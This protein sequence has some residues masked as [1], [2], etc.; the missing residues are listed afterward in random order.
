VKRRPLS[1]AA[2]FASLLVLS[3][4]LRTGEVQKRAECKN[5]RP[6]NWPV[7]LDDATRKTSAVFADLGAQMLATSNKIATLHKAGDQNGM[8]Q[9]VADLAKSNPQVVDFALIDKA[10]IMKIV[11]PEECR[12]FEG[13]DISSQEQVQRALK[14]KA[15][16]SKLFLAVEGFRALDMEY[17]VTYGDGQTVGAVSALIRPEQF[18]DHIIKP[19]TQGSPVDI[20]MMDMDGA[21]LYD[22]DIEEIGRNL[23][24]DA[25]YQPYTSLIE[26]GRKIV[27]GGEEGCTQYDFLATGLKRPMKKNAF[28][29]KIDVLG[30][31]WAL[32]ATVAADP[33]TVAV[34]GNLSNAMPAED[35]LRALAMNQKLIDAIETDKKDAVLEILKEHYSRYP[36]YSVQ[37]VTNDCV[38]VGGFP[39]ENSLNNYKIDAVKNSSDAE[40]V[41]KVTEGKESVFD[42]PLMEGGAG[43]THLV[44]V[45]TG[46]RRLGMIYSISILPKR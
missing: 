24:T 31:R 18:L 9:A 10:G 7:L 3:A 44:P 25:L 17:P 41:K 27:A 29:R 1:S 34:Q 37:W 33:T 20:W 26:A 22:P 42:M 8:R 13:S 15:V 16:M 5:Q 28:W 19:M 30:E 12:K 45:L 43:R 32:V 35:A 40:F 39:P 36:C 4:C 46:G 2:L 38:A 23:F 14:G 11:E 6:A 21:I